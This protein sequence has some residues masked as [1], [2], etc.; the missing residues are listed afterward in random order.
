M[1]S[2][3][4]GDKAIDLPTYGHGWEEIR[5]D[6]FH[7]FHVSETNLRLMAESKV[8]GIFVAPRTRIP[9]LS[10]PTPERRKHLLIQHWHSDLSSDPLLAYLAFG[11]GTLS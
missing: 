9:S 5:Q 8:H 6:C 3:S 10:F 1:V 2:K 11:R 7:L 4:L